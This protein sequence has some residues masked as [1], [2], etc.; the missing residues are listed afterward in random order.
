MKNIAYNK[1]IE[2]VNSTN[3]RDF[4]FF[5]FL[6]IIKIAANRNGIFKKNDARIQLRLLSSTLQLK[7]AKMI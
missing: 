3:K 2:C 7:P 6:I 1:I 4:F 5:H